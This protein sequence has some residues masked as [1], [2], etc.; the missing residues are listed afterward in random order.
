[1][2][3]ADDSEG[4]AGPGGVGEAGGGD[5][6]FHLR[7]AGELHH[8]V[9]Q[10]G[11]GTGFA[12]D[13]AAEGRQDVVEV[14][15]VEPADEASGLVALEDGNL[16]SGAEDAVEFG[17]ACGVAGEVAEPEG[18]G[19]EVD[20]VVGEGEVEGVGFDGEDV[21]VEEFGL[22]EGEHLVGE[23]GGEDGGWPGETRGGITSHP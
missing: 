20:G 4:V 16:A 11:V 2:V 15:R 23:V 17:E 19:D 12:G 21:A 6:G 18:G 7:R 22:G 1:V 9:G 3:E 5:E 8:R 14:E 13:Q 10:V